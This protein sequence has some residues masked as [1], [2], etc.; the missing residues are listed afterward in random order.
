MLACLLL[1]LTLRAGLPA[2][3]ELGEYD[4]KGEGALDDSSSSKMIFNFPGFS[5]CNLRERSVRA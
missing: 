4:D 1:A 3:L 5:V 2:R